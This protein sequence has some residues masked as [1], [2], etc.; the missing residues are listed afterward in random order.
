[1]I[2]GID[3]LLSVIGQ[4]IRLMGCQDL[5]NLCGGTPLDG[6]LAG[7]FPIGVVI[8]PHEKTGHELLRA[9]MIQGVVMLK[10]LAAGPASNLLDDIHRQGI[11][12]DPHFLGES[13]GHVDDFI[14][15]RVEEIRRDAL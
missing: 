13:T 1:M 12:I 3:L 8:P 10:E 11:G 5:L 15:H 4:R 14:I 6:L 7:R 2:N 9:K